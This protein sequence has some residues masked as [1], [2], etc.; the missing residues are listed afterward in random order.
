MPN[1][2]RVRLIGSADIR[3]LKLFGSRSTFPKLE[4]IDVQDALGKSE[5]WD[6]TEIPEAFVRKIR[7]W[8]SRH[9]EPFRQLFTRFPASFAP[10]SVEIGRGMQDVASAVGRDTWALL[11]RLGSL[12]R[13]S[14]D[15]MRSSWLLA[16]FPPNLEELSV[17]F[18]KFSVGS[19]TD[20]ARLANIVSLAQPTVRLAIAHVDNGLHL[21]YDDDESFTRYVKERDFWTSV[22]AGIQI[23]RSGG[24]LE[25]DA[26]S[27]PCHCVRLSSLAYPA[28]T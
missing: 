13:V 5:G 2:R 12:K 23:R 11:C 25:S 9:F 28:A 18:I 16:G 3:V 15:S 20:L 27:S 7:H 1:L 4:E 14:L 17:E 19:D 8:S 26:S 24:S 10:E 21:V 6:A 22:G